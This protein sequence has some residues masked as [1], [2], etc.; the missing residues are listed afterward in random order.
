MTPTNPTPERVT[1]PS[2]GAILIDAEDRADLL[3][4]GYCGSWFI[5]SAK[6]GHQTVKT[7]EPGTAEQLPLAHLILQPPAGEKVSHRDGDRLNLTRRNLVLMSQRSR[8]LREGRDAARDA[9][10]AEREALRQAARDAKAAERAEK[11]A[12]AA[13]RR[14]ARA[15]HVAEHLASRL[16]G[17]PL[18]RGVHWT[19]SGYRGEVYR[20]GVKFTKH[21]RTV[22]EADTFV[23]DIRNQLAAAAAP[24]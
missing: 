10:T 2:G 23:T 6:R 16:G 5:V 12:Q 1:L 7:I 13:D 4:R 3:A 17:P 19:P 18:P 8:E 22:A 14:A 11:S 21:C 9:L 20:L 15:A 24:D